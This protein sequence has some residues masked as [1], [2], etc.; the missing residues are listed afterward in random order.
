MVLWHRWLFQ[1]RKA[2][3]V[4]PDLLVCCTPWCAEALCC[5]ISVLE[6]LKISTSPSCLFSLWDLCKCGGTFL[7]THLQVSPPPPC[8]W[9]VTREESGVAP[10]CWKCLHF[11]WGLV[12]EW[13]FSPALLQCKQNGW[14]SLTSGSD[15]ANDDGHLSTA[16]IHILAVHTQD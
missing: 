6:Q 3:L 7:F 4:A 9:R 8:P 16:S 15:P 12:A 1:G 2:F 11:C 14:A 10:W 5:C 13:G